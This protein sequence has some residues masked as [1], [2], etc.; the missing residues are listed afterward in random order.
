MSCDWC[1]KCKEL[2]FG[3]SP[4]RCPPGWLIWVPEN[5]DEEDART[6]YGYGA[7][8]AIESWAKWWDPDNDNMLA[9]GCEVRVQV[10]M[11]DPARGKDLRMEGEEGLYDVYGEM[12]VTYDVHRVRVPKPAGRSEGDEP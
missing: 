5:G 10:K 12:A 2:V 6:F 1:S 8:K 9:G 7:T 3:S 11:A 4:H